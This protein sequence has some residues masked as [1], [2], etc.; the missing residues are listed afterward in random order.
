MLLVLPEPFYVLHVKCSARAITSAAKWTY[1]HRRW[2]VGNPV[3]CFYPGIIAITLVSTW[4]DS[5]DLPSSCDSVQRPSHGIYAVYNQARRAIPLTIVTQSGSDYFLKLETASRGDLVMSAFVHGGQQLET[6]VP[7]GTFVV[8]HAAGKKWCGE[9]ALFGFE[10]I[11]KKGEHN[12]T[13]DEDHEY[14]LRLIPQTFGNF[15]TMSIPRR[16][17]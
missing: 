7:R 9:R 12:V 13:F 16:D 5:R 15:P 8:K 10:T 17:F 11:T 14:T 6:M 3:L 2:V 4:L 1:K